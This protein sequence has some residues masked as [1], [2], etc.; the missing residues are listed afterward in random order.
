M[1]SSE[2][3]T[4]DYNTDT[5]IVSV[6]SNKSYTTNQEDTN[7][8]AAHSTSRLLARL[9]LDNKEDIEPYYS[10]LGNCILNYFTKDLPKETPF[11]YDDFIY[12]IISRINDRTFNITACYDILNRFIGRV[13]F[14]VIRVVNNNRNNSTTENKSTILAQLNAHPNVPRILSI[15]G[16]KE[17]FDIFNAYK[18][19]ETPTA[20]N[21]YNDDNPNQIEKPFGHSLFLKSFD[22]TTK[23]LRIKDADGYSYFNVPFELIRRA[24]KE[25]IFLKKLKITSRTAKG[26]RKSIKKYKNIK[27]KTKRNIRTQ[28]THKNKNNNHY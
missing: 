24:I 15:G 7:W 27:N 20:W 28:H 22:K 9:L 17:F 6:C 10:K 1:S 25:I 23:N 5:S 26:V 2:G 11:L 12:N 16:T 21:K 18:I 14:R 8:C 3:S 4:P 13:K 19:D